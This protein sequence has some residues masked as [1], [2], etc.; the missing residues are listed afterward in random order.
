MLPENE[1]T[2]LV[3]ETVIY[4]IVEDVKRKR[5]IDIPEPKVSKMKK[6]SKDIEKKNV[7]KRQISVSSS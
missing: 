1:S 6:V 7:K 5:E 3:N 2:H 4:D